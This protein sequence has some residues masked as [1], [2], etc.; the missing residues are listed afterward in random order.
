[1]ITETI[2]QKLKEGNRRFY[3]GKTIHP[4]IGFDRLELAAKENQGDHAYATIISCSDSRVPVE[5]IF[6]AGVMDLFVVRVAGNVCGT[7]QCGSIEYGLLYVNTPVLVV[8]GHTQ[9]GAVTAATHA[10]QGKSNSFEGNISPLIERIKPAVE[11]SIKKYS[12]QEETDL[13][14]YAIEENVYQSMRDLF[15]QSPAVRELVNKGK[16]IAVGA[17]YDIGTGKIKWLPRISA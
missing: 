4:H 5:L 7:D 2:L 6:D 3:E 12:S 14:S 10:F 11:H 8:M 9:C 1:M 13:I 15:K 16:V 17:V